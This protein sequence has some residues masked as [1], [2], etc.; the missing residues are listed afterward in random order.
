M[1]FNEL[2][3]TQRRI[4][5]RCWLSCLPWT[6]MHRRAGDVERMVLDVLQ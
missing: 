1:R 4:I 3:E 6:M 2:L 5:V